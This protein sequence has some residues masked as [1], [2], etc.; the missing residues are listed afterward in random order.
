MNYLLILYLIDLC[1]M[2]YYNL[3]LRLILI[4]LVILAIDRHTKINRKLR[5]TEK[6]PTGSYNKLQIT[7][8]SAI[9]G[10]L[11]FI[12]SELKDFV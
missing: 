9:I 6:E 11:Y 3:F 2:N 10:G 8:I 12:I 7:G 4:P 5:G 1:K